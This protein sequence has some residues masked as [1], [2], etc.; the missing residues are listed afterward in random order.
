MLK[1]ADK[2]FFLLG[3]ETLATAHFGHGLSGPANTCA[4]AV[5][6]PDM[7]G[8]GC[9]HKVFCMLGF[10]YVISYRFS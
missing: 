6:L 5:R 1:H 3:G 8:V 2:P 7:E 4:T 10:S 9:V